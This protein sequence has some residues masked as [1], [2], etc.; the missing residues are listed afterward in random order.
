MDDD[1]GRCGSK[2]NGV[3]SSPRLG[4]ESS[5]RPGIKS[6][7][8]INTPGR[9]LAPFLDF[10]WGAPG[11]TGAVVSRVAGVAGVAPDIVRFLNVIFNTNTILNILF[12]QFFIYK[13]ITIYIQ[14]I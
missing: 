7:C 3:P 9:L 10:L 1:N 5:S 2:W 13:T 11:H 12:F 8:W 6:G 4:G 14:T